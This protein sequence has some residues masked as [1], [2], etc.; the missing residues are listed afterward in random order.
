MKIVANQC[1]DV[2]SYSLHTKVGGGGRKKNKLVA[3]L[4]EAPGPA[5]CAALSPPLRPFP[6]LH[7][8]PGAAGGDEGI[9]PAKVTGP[10]RPR[11]P[12]PSETRSPPS[13]VPPRRRAV[14][15]RALAPFVK[16]GGRP[17]RGIPAAASPACDRA[18]CSCCCPRG[19]RCCWGRSSRRARAAGAGA[20]QPRREGEGAG[21]AGPGRGA[22][23]TPS[24]REAAAGGGCSS[25]LTS[26]PPSTSGLA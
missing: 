6:F 24:R 11:G 23:G 9:S 21:G 17:R 3:E 18:S 15:G 26:P 25:G 10:S 1:Y 4:G 14:P 12:P 2:L 5:R 22:L 13:P 19:C 20:G 7:V 16:L 8:P